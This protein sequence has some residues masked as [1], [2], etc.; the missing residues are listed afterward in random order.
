MMDVTLECCCKSSSAAGRSWYGAPESRSMPDLFRPLETRAREPVMKTEPA[1]TPALGAAGA[2][3]A[4]CGTATTSSATTSW[5]PGHGMA[6][7]IGS[8]S[9]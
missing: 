5:P 2:S 8:S 7:F 6:S 1:T 3:P 9:T 4:A